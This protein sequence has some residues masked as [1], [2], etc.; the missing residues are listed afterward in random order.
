[1]GRALFLSAAVGSGITRH[2][3]KGQASAG[4]VAIRPALPVQGSRQPPHHGLALRLTWRFAI[5]ERVRSTANARRSA[6]PI[7]YRIDNSLRA[8]PCSMPLVGLQAPLGAAQHAT[9]L[10]LAG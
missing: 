3:V 1:V 8:G 10:A 6:Q 9:P 4:Q 5:A 7:T 2:G